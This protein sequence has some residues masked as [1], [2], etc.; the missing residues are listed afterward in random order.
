MSTTHRELSIKAFST[1]EAKSIAKA[2][3]SPNEQIANISEVV[4][5]K[6]RFLGLFGGRQGEY[7]VHLQSSEPQTPPPPAA[8]PPIMATPTPSPARSTH[9]AESQTPAPAAPVPTVAEKYLDTAGYYLTELCSRTDVGS[10]VAFSIDQVAF[11][12][13]ETELVQAIKLE[14]H[15]PE[16]NYVLATAK[17]ATG[18]MK[19]GGED[20]AQLAKEHPNYVEAQGF[21]SNSG[22]WRAPFMYPRWDEKQTRV[23][24]EILPSGGSEFLITSTTDGCRRIVAFFRRLPPN[25]L[26]PLSPSLRCAIRVVHVPTPHGVVIGA[27]TLIDTHPVEPYTSESL[28]NVEQL[29]PSNSE[30]S[31]ASYWLVRLLC[32]QKYTY[33]VLSDPSGEVYFNRK[34]IFDPSTLSMLSQVNVK[35]RDI[36]P[37]NAPNPSRWQAA[38]KHYMDAFSMDDVHF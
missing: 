27:Y 12:M 6:A 14:P 30:A 23:T 3:A 1:E 36:S 17:R 16:Y 18:M 24:N 13:I 20:I 29:T 15:N 7:K 33:V 2:Q 26:P 25:K 4:A 22:A 11:M 35:L 38:Q 9:V 21:M 10:T 37:R 34:V 32:Q 5:P 28:L 19:T 31:T 8:T